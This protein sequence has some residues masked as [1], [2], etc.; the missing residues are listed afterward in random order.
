MGHG[1]NALFLLLGSSLHEHVNG[2]LACSFLCTWCHHSFQLFSVNSA[3][4]SFLR[5]N[6]SCWGYEPA[7]RHLLPPPHVL[8]PLPLPCASPTRT[9]GCLSQL[10]ATEFGPLHHQNHL[11]RFNSYILSLGNKNRFQKEKPG[12]HIKSPATSQ[13]PPVGGA[14]APSKAVSEIT[15]SCSCLCLPFPLPTHTQVHTENTSTGPTATQRERESERERESAQAA[16]PSSCRKPIT[17]GAQASSLFHP[18][19]LRG[20][21]GTQHLLNK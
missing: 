20:A 13:S 19:T 18:C 16:L 7:C 2:R 15:H 17:P 14:L 3:G 5:Q 8:L 9:A 4:D 12:S 1:Q 6:A 21:P 10:A 11:G